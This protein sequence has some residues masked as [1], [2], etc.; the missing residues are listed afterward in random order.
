MSRRPASPRIPPL[1]IEEQG[2]FDWGALA[3][4]VDLPVQ[5]ILA[6]L[7]RHPRV[8]TGYKSFVGPLGQS[9]NL[10]PRDRELL[11]LRTAWRCQ[12]EYEWGRHI[13]WAHRSGLTDVEI[14]RLKLSGL[15][16]DWEPF[17]AILVRA[18]DELHDD[19]CIGDETWSVLATRY[20]ESQLIEVPMVVGAYHVGAFAS[21]SL[22][23]GMEVGDV[24]F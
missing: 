11:V 2:E 5:N 18:A 24:G 3:G 21:N 8:L 13:R 23:I 20:D 17:D 12:A 10:P 7:A 15:S 14:D 22:G 1:S 16:P 6:T 4:H 9:G 19:A